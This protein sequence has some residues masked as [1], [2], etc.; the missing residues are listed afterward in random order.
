[1][2][3]AKNVNFG[4]KNQKKIDKER[5]KSIQKQIDVGVANALFNI[6]ESSSR[7]NRDVTTEEL[8]CHEDPEY[9][10][11]QVTA[12]VRKK[13]YEVQPSEIKRPQSVFGVTSFTLKV[14]W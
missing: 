11:E 9:V 5:R 1:M 3:S 2:E 10:R 12:A 7:G 8:L 4:E 6:K 14:K 13:G